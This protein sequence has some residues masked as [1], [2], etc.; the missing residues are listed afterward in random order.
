MAS[1]L[2]GCCP[3][4]I[5]VSIQQSKLIS[6]IS[7]R[8]VP[9]NWHEIKFFFFFK[10]DLR[11]EESIRNAVLASAFVS[12]QSQFYLGAILMAVLTLV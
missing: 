1:I 8:S 6:L 11:G 2:C 5:P 3:S 4:F 12:K 9:C 7:D 10:V